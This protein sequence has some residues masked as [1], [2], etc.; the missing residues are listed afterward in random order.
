MKEQQVG[1]ISNYYKKISVAVVELK[2]GTLGTGDTVH[3][4]GHTTD[5]TQAVESMQIEHE[6][7]SG[8][9]TGD[10]IGLKVGHRVRKGDKVY[11]VSED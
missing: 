5:F 6:S 10:S 1:I 7:V 2:K 9:K 3:I 8:A 4:Q 11:K